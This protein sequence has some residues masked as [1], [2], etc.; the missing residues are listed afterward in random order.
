MASTYYEYDG[1]NYYARSNDL[2]GRAP[3][4][5]SA[6]GRTLTWYVR[7]IAQGASAAQYQYNQSGVTYNWL[8]IG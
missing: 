3:L 6:D 1:Y 7:G 8:A 5:W 2:C 4:T